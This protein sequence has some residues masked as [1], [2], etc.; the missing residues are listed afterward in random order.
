MPFN[1]RPKR[2]LALRMLTREERIAGISIFDSKAWEN[3]KR[4]NQLKQKKNDRF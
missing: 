1:K 2:N 3:R 4:M